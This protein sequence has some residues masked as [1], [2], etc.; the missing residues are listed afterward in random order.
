MAG[1]TGCWKKVFCWESPEKETAEE[2]P[3][4]PKVEMAAFG[5]PFRREVLAVLPLLLGLF[6]TVCFFWTVGVVEA[7]IL[8]RMVDFCES[9]LNILDKG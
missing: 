8:L 6:F 1:L 3:L 5:F 2:R 7:D 4:V 9:G